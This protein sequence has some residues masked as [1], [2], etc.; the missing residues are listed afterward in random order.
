MSVTRVFHVKIL[1][2]L[3]SRERRKICD[4]RQWKGW[5]INNPHLH[6]IDLSSISNWLSGSCL[7]VANALCSALYSLMVIVGS[8][9]VLLSCYLLRMVFKCNNLRSNCNNL[10]NGTWCYLMIWKCQARAAQHILY[11]IS[12]FLGRG[13][14]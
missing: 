2:Y 9:W 10:P 1:C 13:S 6:H 3:Q 11:I 7:Q 14:F 5:N 8:L 4:A 12:S